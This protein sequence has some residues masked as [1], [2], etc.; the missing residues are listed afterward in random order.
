MKHRFNIGQLLLSA[1]GYKGLFYPGIFIDR[2]NKTGSITPGEDF[3]IP[4]KA[5]LQ[6]ETST[7]TPIYGKDARGRYYFMPVILGGLE[8]PAAVIHPSGGKRIEKT[9]LPGGAGSIKELIYQDDWKIEITGMLW[10]QDRTYPEDELVKIRDLCARNE[11]VELVCA[12]TDIL[13]GGN[14]QV[15][16]ESYDFP[17]MGGSE[18]MQLVKLSCVTD[19]PFELE[20]V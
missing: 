3:N 13:L 20:I 9:P 12:L 11:S 8:I 15:V 7:G 19:L 5:S 18:D 1:A 16:I 4:S 10:N 14:D 6:L 17:V 2:L